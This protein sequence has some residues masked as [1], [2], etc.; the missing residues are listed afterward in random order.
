MKFTFLGT[1]K[2]IQVNNDVTS[3]T[4]QECYSQ[5][6]EWVLLDNNTI[7][8]QAFRYVGG[9]PLPGS[10]ALGI[11]YF[12]LNGWKIRPYSG[13]HTLTVDGNLYSEDGSSPYT[14][15]L[16][17]VSVMII[18]SVSTLVDA[19]V[20]QLPEIEYNTFNN[21]VTIDI[22]NGTPGTEY[23]HGTPIHPVNNVQDALTILA[24]RG[25]NTLQLQSNVT[26]TSGTNLDNLLIQSENWM[27][28]VLEDGVSLENTEFTKV[29]L[30]GVMGGFWNVLNDCW[31]YNITNF[32]GWLRSGSFVYIELA[33]YTIDSAG[34]SFF[35]SVLPMYPNEP[36][37]LVMNTDTAISFTDSTDIIKIDN[38]TSGSVINIGLSRGTVIVDSSCVGGNISVMGIGQ[39][40]N[41]SALEVN[42]SKLINVQLVSETTWSQD[43]SATQFS[44]NGSIGSYIKN[45]VLSVSKFLGLK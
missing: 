12:L 19:T 10:K 14:K 2:I 32:C 31:V 18:N 13:D 15:A 42:D 30:Y 39:V 40:V 11:T 7:Y 17:S 24:S 35:D 8:E 28:V 16:G 33:P 22:D 34:Q 45:K 5:W 26:F 20:Q 43:I 4:C 25:F 36:S 21:K 23:P 38:M 1:E 6:K 9:D 27:E 44:T 37:T 3:F 29:S 41:N